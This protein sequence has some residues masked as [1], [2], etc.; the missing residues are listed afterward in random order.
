VFLGINTAKLE[1]M[2]I[3]DIIMTLKRTKKKKKKDLFFRR[4]FKLRSSD[5]QTN[6]LTQYKR[7]VVPERDG[8]ITNTNSTLLN[9]IFLLYPSI[10]ITFNK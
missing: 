1:I 7:K 5:L 8:F 4:I 6:I 2:A 9:H 10:S 3:F